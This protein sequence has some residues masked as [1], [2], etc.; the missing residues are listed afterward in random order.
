MPHRAKSAVS[1]ATSTAD[2]SNAY[3]RTAQEVTLAVRVVPSEGLT[4]REVAKR[5]RQQGPNV[6]AKIEQRPLIAIFFDRFKDPLVL[7]LLL[8]AVLSLFLRE[9]IDAI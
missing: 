4:Q 9:A 8:A 1:S 2:T 6:I 3:L 7:F 5:Q